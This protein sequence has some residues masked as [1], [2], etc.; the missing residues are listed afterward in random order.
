MER[1]AAIKCC[2]D[3]ILSGKFYEGN[4]GSLRPSYVLT[5]YGEKISRVNLFG[6]VVD[7]FSSEDG[8]YA[9]IT[10]N[11]FSGAIRVKAFRDDAEKLKN[12]E[13]GS[14]VVVIGKPRFWNNELY[15]GLEIIR[16]ID[17]PNFES[18]RRAEIL[19]RLIERKKIISEIL[20]LRDKIDE[21]SFKNYVEEKFGLSIDEIN[22]ILQA[23]EEKK[24]FKYQV[25]KIIKELDKG[26][27]VDIFE[28]FNSIN[29][30]STLLDSILTE[31]INEGKIYESEPGKIK[32]KL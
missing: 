6:T 32:V 23:K 5:K 15:I 28:I 19:K 30:E 9:T 29:L 3:E 1:K 7:K 25:L 12:I 21:E 4:K 10:I 11:D 27:G 24:D 31:L 14:N 20:S 16:V 18:Y 13:I 17:D 26:D 8:S 22:F 2:I